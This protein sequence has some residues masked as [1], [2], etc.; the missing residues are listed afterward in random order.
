MSAL[1]GAFVMMI[2]FEC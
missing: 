1:H 2:I